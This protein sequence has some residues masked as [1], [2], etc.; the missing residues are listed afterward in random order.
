MAHQ[1]Q[2]FQ[3][4]QEMHNRN[5]EIFHYRD[6]QLDN[7]AIHHHDFYEVFLFL[8]GNVE[9][10][11]EGRNYHLERGDIL[12]ISPLE[13]HQVRINMDQDPYERY[14]LWLDARY[15]SSLSTLNTSLTACFDGSRPNHTNLLRTSQ[16]RWDSVLALIQK[17]ARETYGTAYGRD[18]AGTGLLLQL[19]VELNRMSMENDLVQE[20]EEH[21]SVLVARVMDYIGQ[22]YN[23]ALSLER[24]AGE[25][26]ISKYHLSHEFNRVVGT[27]MYRY[28]V[29][30]RLNIATQMLRDG[31]PASDAA[32][33]CGYR[34]YANF[35]RAFK[36][37]YGLSPKRYAE[38][39]RR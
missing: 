7:V 33:N 23:E 28:I 25:F 24:L 39:T 5:F 6:V 22:H 4:R 27:S 11:I 3:P 16:D 35:Y 1:T 31:V 29:L 21:S 36:D 14:V 2:R 19:L 17:L 15:L 18:I 37:E 13:L 26:Y 12:L 38:W 10:N 20:T 8:G 30:K 32:L 9:Y 34:D